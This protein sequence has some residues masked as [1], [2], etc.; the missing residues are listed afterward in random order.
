MRVAI[1][2]ETFLPK[3][4]GIVT[5]VCLLLDH[6]AARGIEAVVV[7]PRMGV[8]RYRNMPVITVPGIPFPFYRE[9]RVGPANLATYRQLQQFQPQIAHFF[10]PI[11]I[12]T[13][14]LLMARWLGI[15]TI[16]SF[17]LDLSRA[18]RYY[19]LGIVSPLSRL[20]TRVVFN[21]ADARL[22]PS[23]RMQ[24][25]LTALGLRD[26]GLWRRGVDSERF[27]PRFRCHDMRRQLSD[28]HPDDT[29][30]LYVGRV[31]HEKQLDHLKPVLER[32]PHTRL[33]IIGDGPARAALGARFSG[34]PVK[35]VGYLQGDALSSAYASADCFVFPSSHET[36]GLVVTEALASGT[37]V[38][39]YRVG[40][41]EDV[42]EEGVTGFSYAVGDIEGLVD[43]VRH[44]AADPDRRAAMGRA[45]RALAETLSWSSVMDDIVALYARLIREQ[46]ARV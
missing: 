38:V 25:E 3:I 31:S 16:A 1:F 10:H 11:L 8:D 41:V 14:G 39:A 27:H 44:I 35:F 23:R 9:I 22:A 34:L 13:P 18:A 12:G 17:H 19:G 43:G 45:A 28:D 21:A 2:T 36:F 42:V 33:A 26:V 46:A 15:P 30:L 40:G 7:A 6:L 32:V 24:Q 20:A 4:D 37:P 29:L 5:V